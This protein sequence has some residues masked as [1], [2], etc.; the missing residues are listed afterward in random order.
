M[1]T[2]TLRA[3]QIAMQVIGQNISNANTPGYIREEL[4]LAPAPTQRCGGLLLGMGVQVVAVVQMIDEFLEE[5]LRGAISQREGS[6]VQEDTYLQFEQLNNDLGDNGLGTLLNNFFASIHEVLNQQQSVSVR[7]LVVLQGTTL[8]RGITRL[9]ERTVELR[10]HLND[11][12]AAMA[13]RINRLT[14]QIQTLNIR[15][16]ETEGGDISNSDAVGLRDQRLVALE[17]LAKLVNIRVQEQKSGGVNVYCGGDFLVAEGI[18]REVQATTDASEG[19]ARAEIRLVE[20]NSAL[21]VTAGKL[22]GL[23][24][25]RDD[26]LGDFL[27]RLNDFARTLAFEFNKVY[28]S[29]QGLVGYQELTSEF[30]VHSI[31]ARLDQAGLPFTP[32]NGSFQVLVQNTRT[33]IAQYHTI[34]MDLLD[35]PGGGAIHP[36]GVTTLE[37]LADRLDAIDG[38]SAEVTGTRKLRL[39]TEASDQVFAFA[40]D[41]SGL[42]AALGLNTFFSGSSATDLGVNPVVASN[43]ATFAASAAG[44]GVDT[45][46]AIEL[47]AFLDRPIASRNGETLAVIYDRMM[48][49]T[50][51][52]A[53]VARAEADGARVFEETLR[54]QKLATSGVNLDEEVVRLIGY[55]RSFQAAARFIAALNELFEVLVKL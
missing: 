6:E 2:N 5:R 27:D 22:Y 34:K 36:D 20:T 35:Y 42:L 4:V 54:G 40:N 46:V 37:E 13:E 23:Q 47:A 39:T 25:A 29:G 3:D 18:R 24:V 55:Q 17:E 43:P 50:T 11:N 26:I 53:A 21:E 38:L 16:A 7:N 33:G 32:T 49:E 31:D 30:A 12:V 28:S 8:A 19:F 10:S 15:I 9:A 45:Q 14:E 41:T 52:G 44:I 48:S 51:Q 1:V